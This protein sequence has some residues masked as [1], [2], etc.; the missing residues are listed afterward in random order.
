MKA[1]DEGAQIEAFLDGSLFAVV[2]ASTNRAKY[3]NKILR[4]YMQNGRNAVPINPAASTVEGLEAKATLSAMEQ[5]VDGVSI[6]TPPEVTEQVIEEIIALG[7]KH[8]WIQPGAE[9]P[10]ALARA[11]EAGLNCIA[12][13]ACL[14]VVLG[15][16]EHVF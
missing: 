14:L 15:Y 7:I 8:V 10:K 6:I 1:S 4:C 16:R 9:S 5:S 13:G 3:G 11:A 12:G 2:G